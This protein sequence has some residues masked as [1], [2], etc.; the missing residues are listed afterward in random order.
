MTARTEEDGALREGC[1][2]LEQPWL[3]VLRF[4]RLLCH[5]C[6]VGGLGLISSWWGLQQVHHPCQHFQ[7]FV[8]LGEA[9]L[10]VGIWYRPIT[11]C[12]I[13]MHGSPA[14]VRPAGQPQLSS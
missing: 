3:T 12:W 6:A 10:L 7:L 9:A 5:R 8:S 11:C 4:L 13:W 2:Q 14:V 1:E